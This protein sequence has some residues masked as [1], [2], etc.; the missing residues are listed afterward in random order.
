MKIDYLDELLTLIK[1][2]GATPEQY[3]IEHSLFFDNAVVDFAFNEL[4]TKLRAAQSIHVRKTT[5]KTLIYK[6]GSQNVWKSIYKNIPD[7]NVIIDSDGNRKV[8]S[9]I[10]NLTGETISQGVNSSIM[11]GKI[12]HIWGEATNPLFFTALWNIVLVP[13]Y[14]NDILDKNNGTHP[15]ITRIKEIY[16]SI[17]WTKYNVDNK[18]KAL[19]LT[20]KEINQYAPDV[21]VLTGLTYKLTVIP[22]KTIAGSTP[23][24]KT[25]KTS[26]STNPFATYLRKVINSRGR[27][28]SNK[29]IGSYCSAL[30]CH[31]FQTVL[32][33][34]GL[35]VD[36]Y[37]CTD[38]TA[39]KKVYDEIKKKTTS[40]ARKIRDERHGSCTSAIREYAGYLRNNTLATNDSG[41]SF[42]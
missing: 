20:Q 40:I 19:G 2:T 35:S 15:F 14:F 36:I 42:S 28:Y 38:I 27:H 37:Q 24:L 9:L 31:D 26:C 8:R 17:C 3:M 39:L 7:L 21:S 13:A 16:K 10:T 32:T 33:K 1:S 25:R 12:S 6:V 22:M 41:Q 30:N 29:T 34:H 5:K 23:G 4:L 18:L 11:F